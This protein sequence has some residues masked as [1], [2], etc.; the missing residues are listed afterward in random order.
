MPSYGVLLLH[1]AKWVLNVEKVSIVAPHLQNAVPG[2]ACL[3]PILMKFLFF[4]PGKD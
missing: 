3:L 2:E 4:F 1:E